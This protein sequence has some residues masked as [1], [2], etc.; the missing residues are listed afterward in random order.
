[1]KEPVGKLPVV[2]K[3]LEG[4]AVTEAKQISLRFRAS[5]GRPYE[6][7]I[8]PDCAGMVIAA[9]AKHLGDLSP[10][11]VQPIVVTGVQPAIFQ[12]GSPVLALVLE[13]GGELV[14]KMGSGDLRE[15]IAQLQH[16]G[17]PPGTTRN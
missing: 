15:L 10:T 14:L 9:T 11:N 4:S 16:I 17:S 7:E 8:A 5:D 2:F 3:A 1:M 13:G 12:D 6:I